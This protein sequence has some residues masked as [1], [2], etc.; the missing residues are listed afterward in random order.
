MLEKAR[1][2]AYTVH[3]GQTYGDE[4]YTVHLEEVVSILSPYGLVAQ[5][6]GYL[7]DTVEDTEATLEHIEDEFGAFY[8]ECIHYL[9]DCEG[10]N[11]VERKAKTNAKLAAVSSEHSVTLIVKAADRLAN[12]RRRGKLKM[13]RRE[14]AEF[15]KAVYREGLCDEIFAEIDEIL[16]FNG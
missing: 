6:L 16:G 13:Y 8:R 14:H 11:R 12:V 2:F 10:V 7:H 3:S 5:I 1:H 15:R 4:P 9:T